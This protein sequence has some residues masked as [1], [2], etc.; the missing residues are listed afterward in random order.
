M[1]IVAC[2]STASAV[3]HEAPVREGVVGET[4]GFPTTK[5]M[6]FLFY[7]MEGSFIHTYYKL[8]L[9]P[10]C[11]YYDE[12]RSDECCYCRYDPQYG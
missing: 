2:R 11:Y 5:L 3:E 9:K 12:F 4:V 1:L 6:N 7:E 8:L 10:Y